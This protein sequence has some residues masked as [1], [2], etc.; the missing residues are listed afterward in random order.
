MLRH[1]IQKHWLGQPPHPVKSIFGRT[2]ISQK[3]RENFTK[4]RKPRLV[5]PCTTPPLTP[6][7]LVVHLIRAS[8]LPMC[9]ASRTN[10]WKFFKFTYGHA[11]HRMNG[12][13]TDTFGNI[14]FFSFQTNS[15]CVWQYLQWLA[16]TSIVPKSSVHLN[17]QVASLHTPYFVQKLLRKDMLFLSSEKNLSR[18]RAVWYLSLGSFDWFSQHFHVSQAFLARTS[19]VRVETG[20]SSVLKKTSV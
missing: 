10:D 17:D 15:Y 3:S 18:L 19:D 7:V 14:R 2:S 8:L 5:L 6:R 12:P 13:R 20:R 16:T 4:I 11:K 9:V 1:K